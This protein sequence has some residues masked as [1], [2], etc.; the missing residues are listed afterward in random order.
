MTVDVK[1]SLMSF[2]DNICQYNK[3]GILYCVYS[4]SQNIV[5]ECI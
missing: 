3:F 1:D 5:L 4:A 2:S